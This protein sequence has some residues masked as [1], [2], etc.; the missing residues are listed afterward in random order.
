MGKI[1]GLLSNPEFESRWDELCRSTGLIGRW[2][3]DFQEDVCQ[4]DEALRLITGLPHFKGE[5]PSIAFLSRIH[6]DDEEKVAKAALDSFES[7]V[8][9]GTSFR[10][11]RGD[12]RYIVMR[13]MGRK[14]E[15]GKDKRPV[16]VG[17]NFIDPASYI[18]SPVPV[19]THLNLKSSAMLKTV[20]DSISAETTLPPCEVV[21][22]KRRAS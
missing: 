6:L 1:M 11:L 22:F 21:T 3:W 2:A 15:I 12:G 7:G 19:K 14:I 10:F 17:I 4:L 9:Y 13:G 20:E 8:P 16:L 18:A 5:F